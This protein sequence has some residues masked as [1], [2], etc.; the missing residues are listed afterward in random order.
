M[1]QPKGSGKGKGHSAPASAR[2]ARGDKQASLDS[3]GVVESGDKPE[4]VPLS[5]SGSGYISDPTFTRRPHKAQPAHMN[6]TLPRSHAQP[7][8]SYKGLQQQAMPVVLPTH[9]S[10]S[11][12]YGEMGFRPLYLQN[13][14]SIYQRSHINQMNGPRLSYSPNLVNQSLGM[15]PTMVQPQ[16]THNAAA[17][18]STSMSS[19]VYQGSPGILTPAQT[20]QGRMMDK[21]TAMLN[22]SENTSQ[23]QM[24]SNAETS[25][26]RNPQLLTTSTVCSSTVTYSTG[27]H[28]GAATRPC[29]TTC[30]CT[31]HNNNVQPVQQG[32]IQYVPQLWQNS[33]YTNNLGIVPPYTQL[34]LHHQPCINGLNQDAMNQ[35]MIGMAHPATQ[36]MAGV[37]NVICGHNY[38]NNFVPPAGGYNQRKQKKLNCHNCGSSKHSA[39]DCTQISMEAMSGRWIQI[40]VNLFLNFIIILNIQ[41]FNLKTKTC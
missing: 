18:T 39:S 35:A 7:D 30:G 6:F 10:S 40:T 4:Q 38:Y 32:S 12:L 25:T 5:S 28:T 3:A 20:P 33:M 16:N 34:Y 29:C 9:V 17:G 26:Y 11:G 24:Q 22:G 13:G 19:M 27:S 1:G 31:G 36:G 21:S 37:P 8:G 41:Q 14:P 2:Y 15:N 23:S